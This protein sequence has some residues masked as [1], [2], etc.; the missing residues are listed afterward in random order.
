MA[1]RPH[2]PF[3]PPEGHLLRWLKEHQVE[4]QMGPVAKFSQKELAVEY[5]VS[6]STVNALLRLLVRTHCVEAVRSGRYRVTE[7]GDL[8]LK[9]MNEIKEITGG[10]HHAD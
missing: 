2:I 8:V 9:K 6:V 1:K 5:G 10:D 7:G 4:T 3:E